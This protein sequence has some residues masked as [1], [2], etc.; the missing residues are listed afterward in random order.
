MVILLRV[1][2]VLDILLILPMLAIAMMGGLSGGTMDGPNQRFAHRIIN[3]LFFYPVPSVIAAEVVYRL[4]RSPLLGL[5]VA[6][7]PIGVWVGY[8]IHLRRGGFVDK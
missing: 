2:Q 7:V 6:L 8:T 3:S 1:V 4:F 5:L